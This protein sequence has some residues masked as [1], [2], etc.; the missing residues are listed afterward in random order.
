MAACRWPL[1]HAG[2]MPLSRDPVKALLQRWKDERT[3]KRR[4]RWAAEVR[5]GHEQMLDTAIRELEEA[6]GERKRLLRG[7]ASGTAA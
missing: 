6:V 7:M 3:S 2:V 5:R 4:E 1:L